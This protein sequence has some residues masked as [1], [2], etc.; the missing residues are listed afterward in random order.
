MK[1]KKWKVFTRTMR[2]PCDEK[3]DTGRVIEAETKKEATISSAKYYPG[4]WCS[5]EPVPELK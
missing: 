2:I 1:N 5:V 4:K 3:I